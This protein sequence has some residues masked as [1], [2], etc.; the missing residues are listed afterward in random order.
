MSFFFQSNVSTLIH[1]IEDFDVRK[2]KIT[3]DE[4]MKMTNM[5]HALLN[6]LIVLHK[7]VSRTPITL[8]VESG[9]FLLDGMLN[10]QHA[11]KQCLSRLDMAR[12]EKRGSLQ[13]RL[14]SFLWTFQFRQC[15]KLAGRIRTLIL[16]HEADLSPPSGKGPFTNADDLMKSLRS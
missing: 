12:K 15:H 10:V 1:A 11:I 8:Q 5:L 14:F 13:F 9:D 7:S 4:E 16:E 3:T 6:Q 2:R